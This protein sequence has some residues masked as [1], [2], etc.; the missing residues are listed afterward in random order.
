VNF[1]EISIPQGSFSRNLGS[2]NHL[3]LRLARVE[4]VSFQTNNRT[5]DSK[6]VPET[7]S[8]RNC[9]TNLTNTYPKNSSA[10]LH[11]RFISNKSPI[12]MKFN[13]EPIKISNQKLSLPKEVP[14][15]HLKMP[16]L[17]K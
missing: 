5:V 7:G 13:K 8:S 16:K 14:L 10:N 11:R 15:T 3:S 4:L 1:E 9:S 6:L 2:S 12:H 17:L